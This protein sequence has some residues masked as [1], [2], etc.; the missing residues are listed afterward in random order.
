MFSASRITRLN[1][2][3][4]DSVLC[5][6]AMFSKPVR[7]SRISFSYMCMTMSLSSAWI[8][9]M[10]ERAAARGRDVG[11]EHLD[12]GMAGLDRLGELTEN[13]GRDVAEQHRV[14]GVIAIAGAGPLL[15]APLDRL[16]D[17]V[18]ALDRGKVDRR[19]RAAEQRRL[20]DPRG[21]LG[22]FRL[23]V[24]HRHRPVA[25]DMRVDPAGDDDLAAGIDHPPN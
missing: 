18:A 7:C 9:A 2:R 5:T 11:G 17:G 21:G 15:V 4:S 16:L 19:R 6:S 10:P 24:G 14:E 12:A 8:A 20:A 13:F 3:S 25:M 22:Q 23:A 1:D